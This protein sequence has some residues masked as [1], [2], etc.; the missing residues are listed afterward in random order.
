MSQEF[1]L[2]RLRELGHFGR[3]RAAGLQV[4]LVEVWLDL[5]GAIEEVDQFAGVQITD[6]DLEQ[7]TGR[8]AFQYRP[9]RLDQLQAGLL[10]IR[11]ER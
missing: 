5:G 7:F 9:K 1:D 8:P 3:H 6:A 10:F 11:C 4:D 2:V